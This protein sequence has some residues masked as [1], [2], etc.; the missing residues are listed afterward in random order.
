MKTGFAFC[1]ALCLLPN[2]ADSQTPAPLKLSARIPLAN[3]MGRMDHIAVDVDG[4]RIFATAFDNHSVEVIDVRAGKQVGTIHDLNQ[5][6]GG[7]YDAAGKRL[8]V[9]SGGDGS[10]K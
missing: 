4:Q 2:I 7:Y 9:A 6:Q 3:V 1:I 10:A 8:F 5:P